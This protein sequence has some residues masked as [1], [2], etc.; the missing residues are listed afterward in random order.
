MWIPSVGTHGAAGVISERR[1]SSCSSSEQKCTHFFSEWCLVGYGTGALWDLSRSDYY[2]FLGMARQ[3]CSHGMSKI[4]FCD[5]MVRNWITVKRI[6]HQVW[7]IINKWLVKWACGLEVEQKDFLMKKT[8]WDWSDLMLEGCLHH[9]TKA[10]NNQHRHVRMK[11]TKNPP[12]VLL[13]NYI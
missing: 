4:S 9:S 10:T 6:C 5:L 7:I 3:V 12:L 8:R 13:G 1:C 2:K 11:W